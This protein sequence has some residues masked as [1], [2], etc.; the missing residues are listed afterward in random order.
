MITSLLFTSA[1][2]ITA[3][4][5][6]WAV[7]H[8]F[9]NI[10]L[11]FKLPVFAVIAW[12]C[13]RAFQDSEWTMILFY[14]LAALIFI[15]LFQM[16]FEKGTWKV[17]DI[18]IAVL[19]LLSIFLVDS[20]PLHTFLKRPL[21]ESI[22]TLTL[23]VFAVAWMFFGSI[24]V[25]HSA[26]LIVTL[27]KVKINGVETQAR[28]LRVTHDYYYTEDANDMPLVLDIYITEYTFQ[29]EDGRSFVGY[30]ELRDNPVSKLSADEFRKQ[31]KNGY[32]LEQDNMIPLGIEYE[33]DNP[34]N[35]RA[36]DSRKGVFDTSFEALA[37]AVFGLWP[38]IS[39]FKA[40][41]ENF[42]ELLDKAKRK[43]PA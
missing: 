9:Y 40:C 15:P 12:G 18:V 33:K 41:K 23:I 37:L 10:N 7:W 32:E 43:S 25:Y 24:L 38:V 30:S 4:L 2:V 16:Q 14:V 13:Y 42:L 6:V 35:N 17:I 22:K 34:N 8:P 28:I 19:L 29:T 1:R 31:Y 3:G 5:L 26:R 27:A 21:G 11:F 39:G 20:A 36:V